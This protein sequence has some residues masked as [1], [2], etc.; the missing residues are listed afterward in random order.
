MT[1]ILNFLL[2]LAAE[3]ILWARARPINQL[4]DVT[5]AHV[6]LPIKFSTGPP[7]LVAEI[8]YNQPVTVPKNPWSSHCLISTTLG[9]DNMS[10]HRTDSRYKCSDSIP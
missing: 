6:D 1:M 7:G 3:M 5:S 2:F 9:L 8:L 4:L 10:T